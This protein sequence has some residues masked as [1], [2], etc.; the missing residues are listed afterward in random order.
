[1]RA[2]ALNKRIE[3]WQTT[4]IS[5]G[6]G[7]YKTFDQRITTSWAK[8]E[9]K[10]QHKRGDERDTEVGMNDYSEQLTITM[11]YRKDI[12]YNSVNQ[13]L[14][15]RGV[16]YTFTMSP[17][18]IDFSSTFIS[19]TASRQKTKSVSVLQ[20][21]AADAETLVVNYKNRTEAKGGTLSSEDCT[22]DYVNSLL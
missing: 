6:F 14:M 19:L 12:A 10:K 20:P 2:R 21:I 17:Q 22:T 1:M 13:F 7:G 3:I 9:T 8:V 11:R 15:Y 4:E 5:D 16:K 18:D